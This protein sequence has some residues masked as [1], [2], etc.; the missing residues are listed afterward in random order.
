MLPD[1]EICCDSFKKYNLVL[2][3]ELYRKLDIY[4]DFLS[5]QGTIFWCIFEGVSFDSISFLKH[6]QTHAN[7]I[8]K[9]S[10]S[11]KQMRE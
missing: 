9:N 11:F 8:K 5:N 6:T 4:A 2:S 7:Q 3:E 1:F 10:N